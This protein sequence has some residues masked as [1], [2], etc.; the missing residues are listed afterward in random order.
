MSDFEIIRGYGVPG[1]RWS[2]YPFHHL[3]VGDAFLVPEGKEETVKS[4]ASRLNASGDGRFTVRKQL[5]GK[6]VAVRVS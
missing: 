2:K 4:L 1:R 5:D 6:Y 3:E